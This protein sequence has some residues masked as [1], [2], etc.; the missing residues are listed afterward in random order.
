MT[1]WIFFLFKPSVPN[2]L[3]AFKTRDKSRITFIKHLPTTTLA[4]LIHLISTIASSL[5][6]NFCTRC[7]ECSIYEYVLMK[8]YSHWEHQREPSTAQRPSQTNGESLKWQSK[9]FGQVYSECALYTMWVMCNIYLVYKYIYIVYK[10][11]DIPRKVLQ[12]ANVVRSS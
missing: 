11:K 4:N 7:A 8:P 1:C 6:S 10:Y 2:V 12:V 9:L 3:P 5:Q